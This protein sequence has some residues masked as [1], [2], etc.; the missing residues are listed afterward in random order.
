MLTNTNIEKDKIDM[1]LRWVNP[2]HYCTDWLITSHYRYKE[3]TGFRERWR[4][5]EWD[6]AHN[7][8]SK[9]NYDF[10]NNY[11]YLYLYPAEFAI[12]NYLYW[13]I[14]HTLLSEHPWYKLSEIRALR[15]KNELMQHLLRCSKCCSKYTTNY[16]ALMLRTLFCPVWHGDHTW[17]ALKGAEKLPL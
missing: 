7:L 2:I 1:K 15:C 12:R 4:R 6:C 16:H 5:W 14:Q 3:A 8:Y 13:T 9:I 17:G 10:W 11:L